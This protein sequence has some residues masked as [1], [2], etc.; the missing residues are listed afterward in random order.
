MSPSSAAAEL[1]PAV[2]PPGTASGASGA[3]DGD[4]WTSPLPPASPGAEP[5]G[6]APEAGG[7]LPGPPAELPSLLGIPVGDGERSPS[8]G[9]APHATANHALNPRTRGRV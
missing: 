1:A 9:D 2:A 7:M 3:P 4:G 8:P 6:G 5:A